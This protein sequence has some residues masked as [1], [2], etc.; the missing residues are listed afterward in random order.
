MEYEPYDTELASRVTSLY[1]Q[2][3]S[4][5]TTVAQLRREAPRNA[6]KSYADALNKVLQEENEEA[7]RLDEEEEQRTHP[8]QGRDDEDVEM[9]DSEESSH[10]DPSW[11]LKIPFNTKQEEERWRNGEMASVYSD[12]LRTLL[13]LQGESVGGE[14]ESSSTDPAP[15]ALATSIGLAERAGKAA[16]VVE[17]I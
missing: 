3:E 12:A 13:R 4:L 16:E 11:E 10:I 1:A 15:R 14:E 9:K 7:R 5:T 17:K 8:R 2:L 6:A